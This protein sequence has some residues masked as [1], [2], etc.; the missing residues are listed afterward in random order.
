[1]K[2]TRVETLTSTEGPIPALTFVRL[3]TD[4]G[5]VGLGE[6]FYTPRT[7]T[8]YVHEVLAP[9][10]SAATSRDGWDWTTPTRAPLVASPAV[11]TCG[12]SPH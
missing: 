12:H 11:S 7:V 9:S 6:T 10:F 1:M 4:E 8:A 3:F 5:V 2:V